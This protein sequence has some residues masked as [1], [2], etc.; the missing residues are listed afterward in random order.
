[1]ISLAETDSTELAARYFS[2]LSGGE[3]QRVL[4]ASILAQQPRIMLLDEPTAALDIHH[5]ADVFSLLRALS[6]KDIAIAVVTHDL[7]A[8]GQFCDSLALLRD[9]RL[10][11]TGT[12]RRVMRED[13][14]AETYQTSLRVVE[15]PVISTPM[16]VVLGKNAHDKNQT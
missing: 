10:V 7:N 16:V 14:L 9:G 15:H 1:M 4:V 6:R 5:K 11:E 8:A 2:T 3:R 13:L 12:P